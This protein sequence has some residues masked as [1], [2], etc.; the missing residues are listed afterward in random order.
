M[1]SSR[2]LSRRGLFGAF[3]PMTIA[4]GKFLLDPNQLPPRK[5]RLGD[6]VRTERVCD[7]RLSPNYGQLEWEA[8]FIV[9]FCWEYSECLPLEPKN[10]WTYW[11]KFTD[12]NYPELSKIAWVDFA[13]ESELT[14]AKNIPKNIGHL[15]LNNH[16]KISTKLPRDPS[17]DN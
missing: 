13:H 10:G 7:D 15:Y 6:R 3:L 12:S 17:L 16:S 9:G 4:A 11:I 14:I 5:F 8:G 1:I 2:K